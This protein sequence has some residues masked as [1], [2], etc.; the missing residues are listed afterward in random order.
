MSDPSAV[1]SLAGADDREI[2]HFEQEKG[3]VSSTL[4]LYV[5]VLDINPFS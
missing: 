5:Y 4:L 2:F 1:N 3:G